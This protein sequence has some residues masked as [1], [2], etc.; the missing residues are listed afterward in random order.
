MSFMKRLHI[1]ILLT[2]VLLFYQCGNDASHSSDINASGAD[3][4]A[5]VGTRSIPVEPK[6]VYAWVDQ[7]RVRQLPTLE[8]PV[9]TEL[10]AGDTL[11]FLNEQTVE[12]VQLTLRE[13]KFNQPWIKVRTKNGREGWVYGGG[14]TTKRDSIPSGN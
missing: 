3:T 1:I 12:K 8:S 13:K 11:F 14:V 7:L 5:Q 2:F 9:V 4:T 6:V 10:A